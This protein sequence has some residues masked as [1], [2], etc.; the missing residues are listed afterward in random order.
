MVTL[1]LNTGEYDHAILSASDIFLQGGA[2][3]EVPSRMQ[4]IDRTYY[5]SE[6]VKGKWAAGNTAKMELRPWCDGA[7]F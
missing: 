7:T 1:R 5:L 2:G 4:I 3:F 6:Q